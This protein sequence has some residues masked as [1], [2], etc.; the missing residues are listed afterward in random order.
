MSRTILLFAPCLLLVVVR[1][2]SGDDNV[3]QLIE[4]TESRFS[5]SLL[6]LQANQ[7]LSSSNRA[8]RFIEAVVG[9]TTKEKVFTISGEGDLT[10][11]K[12][13]IKKTFSLI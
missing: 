7:S 5:G 10:M 12:K 3:V 8:F 6:K 1:F 4:A 9:D 2:V 13:G 11:V